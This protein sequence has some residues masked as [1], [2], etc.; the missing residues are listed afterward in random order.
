MASPSDSGVTVAKDVVYLEMNDHEYL[1][2]VYVPAGD[3]PWPVVVALH[4]VP[5]YKNNSVLTVI[6]KAAAEAGMLVF[7]PNWVAE[8]P[9]RDG[10]R[11]HPG[12]GARDAMCVGVRPTGGSWVRGRFGPHCRLRHS[13]GATSGAMFVLGPTRD[14]TSGML[15]LRPR[16]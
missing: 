2:D 7:A 14:L 9:P 11:I 10:C 4:G 3:G 1:V 12:G 5:V 16:Q 6:A 13:G 15:R 8:W